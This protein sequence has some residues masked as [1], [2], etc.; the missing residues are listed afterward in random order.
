[1][2]R[3]LSIGNKATVVLKEPFVLPEID[4]VKQKIKARVV[5]NT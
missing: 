2:P 4:L 3:L 1:M 5:C